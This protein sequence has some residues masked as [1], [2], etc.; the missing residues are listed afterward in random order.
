[1]KL[2]IH[3]NKKVY[4][5]VVDKKKDY[6]D[7]HDRDFL[8]RTVSS[9]DKGSSRLLCILPDNFIRILTLPLLVL[10]HIRGYNLLITY[11]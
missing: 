9:V 4:I 5:C 8:S 10:I 11:I 2:D 1:M 3:G 7:D 6:C